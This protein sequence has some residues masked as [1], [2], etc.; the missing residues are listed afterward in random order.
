MVFVGYDMWI[1]LTYVMVPVLYASVYLHIRI[2]V[3]GVGAGGGYIGPCMLH[4]YVM[5]KVRIG[6]VLGLPCTEF[7][8]ELCTTILGLSTQSTDCT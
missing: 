8:S 4:V 6:I 1:M 2:E 3:G 7:G 5:H